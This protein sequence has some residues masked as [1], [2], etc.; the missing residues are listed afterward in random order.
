MKKAYDNR[1]PNIKCL[2][3]P[4][5]FSS[6]MLNVFIQIVPKTLKLGHTNFT[7]GVDNSATKG[8]KKLAI[9]K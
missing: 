5:I 3:P 2:F 6:V 9:L 7:T 8:A 4:F 1:I